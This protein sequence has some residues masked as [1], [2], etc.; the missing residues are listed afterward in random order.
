ML[1]FPQRLEESDGLPDKDGE[2]RARSWL[3]PV[4]LGESG[5][6]QSG[7][8]DGCSCEQERDENEETSSCFDA[9]RGS[10]GFHRASPSNLRAPLP[11]QIKKP[12]D[13]HLRYETDHNN[14]T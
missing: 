1:T 12:I 2:S 6:R 7:T 10:T 13:E 9:Y 11:R 8:D 5:Y 3:C 14:T 4:E